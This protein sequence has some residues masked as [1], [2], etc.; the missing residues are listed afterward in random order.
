MITKR[1]YGDFV[2]RAGAVALALAVAIFFRAGHTGAFAQDLPSSELPGEPIPTFSEA[3][4]QT[5]SAQ[6]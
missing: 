4:E 2:S 1:Q 5:I 3:G 6:D